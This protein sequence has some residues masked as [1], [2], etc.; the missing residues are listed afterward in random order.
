MRVAVN[1]MTGC[2]SEKRNLGTPTH[3]DRRGPCEDRDRDWSYTE[4]SQELPTNASNEEKPRKDPPPELEERAR[5][6]LTLGFQTPS[7]P[8]CE[9][10][11]SP[12]INLSV[13]GHLLG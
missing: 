12:V 5:A 7:P 2:P 13:C 11:I 3:T 4:T 6:L 8:H 10:T 9:R 1:P